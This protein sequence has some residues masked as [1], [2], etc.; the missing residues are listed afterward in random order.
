LDVLNT[1]AQARAVVQ[2]DATAVAFGL[3][4]LAL[5]SLV[6]YTTGIGVFVTIATSATLETTAVSIGVES[7]IAS[8]AAAL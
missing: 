7:V 8:V 4:A 3:A 2:A 5:I 6:A 1:Q